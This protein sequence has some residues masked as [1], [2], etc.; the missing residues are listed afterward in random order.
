MPIIMDYDLIAERAYED[1]IFPYK[2]YQSGVKEADKAV[3]KGVEGKNYPVLLLEDN[4]VNQDGYG[5]K[6]GFY[7]LAPDQDKDFLIFYQ[8]GE[9]KA[10]IPIISVEQIE[11]KHKKISKFRKKKIKQKGILEEEYIFSKAQIFYN[12]EEDNYL[13]IW[14]YKN[15]KIKA[16]IKF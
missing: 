16:V 2:R 7:M 8:S 13:V 5:L 4:L 1:D 11:K 15:T 9:I 12:K 3:Y 10:K 14:E 6:K